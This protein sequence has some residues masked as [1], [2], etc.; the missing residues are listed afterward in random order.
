MATEGVFRH[1]ELTIG[2]FLPA[3][4]EVP[5]TFND[6]LAYAFGADAVARMGAT[7]TTLNAV[8]ETRYPLA[9]DVVQRRREL[10]TRTRYA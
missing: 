9:D 10:G 4:A 8:V 2:V 7:P 6:W 1:F 3:D 5:Y